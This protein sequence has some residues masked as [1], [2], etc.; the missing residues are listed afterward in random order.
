MFRGPLG[1]SLSLSWLHCRENDDGMTTSEVPNLDPGGRSQRGPRR[2]LAAPWEIFTAFQEHGCY[3]LA[4]GISFYFMLSL[5]PML[6]LLLAVIGYFLRGTVPVRDDLMAAVHQYIPFLT[7]E[8][9]QNIEQVVQNP[10]LLGWIGGAGLFLSTDLVF[11]AIQSSLDRI[12][13]QSR[14]SFLKSKM[15]SVLLGVMVFCVI[16]LTIAVNAVDTSLERLMAET[17]EF[18]GF[19]VGLHLSTWTIGILLLGS[20]TLAIRML[21]HTHVP[22]RY[23]IWGG[24]MG[25]ALWLLVKSGYVWYLENVSKVGPLFGSLSAVILTLI[26]VYVSSLVFLAGAEF[27]RWLIVTDPTRDMSGT[28]PVS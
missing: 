4:A 19:P 7:E 13:V 9:I 3:F 23:A 6:F 18:G 5:I 27:T 25:A 20:F 14:R 28:R 26:W 12:F 8:I 11:V 2:W 1:S 21:P 15:L 16:L 24:A 10:G 17:A 22:F